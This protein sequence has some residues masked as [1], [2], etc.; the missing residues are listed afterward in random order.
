MVIQLLTH[1]WHDEKHEEILHYQQLLHQLGQC[2]MV[3]PSFDQ[4][5]ILE[6][7]IIIQF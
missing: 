7:K 5:A 1:G 6:Y 2:L 3:K 4:A